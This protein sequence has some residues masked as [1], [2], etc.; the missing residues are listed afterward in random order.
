MTGLRPLW[1]VHTK[2]RA[3]K[4]L[5]RFLHSLRIGHYLPTSPRRH[6]YG[7]RQARTNWS[8][9]FP[10]YVF[11]LQEEIDRTLLF[12]SGAVVRFIPVP[13]PEELYQDLQS[14]WLTLSAKPAAIQETLYQPGVPVEV[15]SGPLK[16]VQGELI[17]TKQ[18]GK[19]LLICVHLLGTAVT[20]DIDAARVRRR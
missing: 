3:E 14:L 9:L 10:G 16:G 4:K 2:P 5:A 20:V 13:N 8:P 11:V 1:A 15:T 12:R 17:R 18:G 7:G 6:V 19:R